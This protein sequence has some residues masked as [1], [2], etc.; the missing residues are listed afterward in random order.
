MDAAS[1]IALASANR[2]IT[3]IKEETLPSGPTITALIA[4]NIPHLQGI[5]GG[6]GARYI[7]DE[8][9]RGALGALPAVE[10]TDIHVS[11]Y[12]A[13][14]DGDDAT[15]RELYS[16]TLPLLVCQAIY[17]MR[18]TKYVLMRRGICDRQSVRAPLPEL[19]AHA[20]KDVDAMIAELNRVQR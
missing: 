20:R 8:L 7:I 15:A 3:Y 12:D 19:D 17:R 4:E 16:A 6:G 9:D 18:L 5:L 2:S 11:I 14:R 10:L 13:H 1:I